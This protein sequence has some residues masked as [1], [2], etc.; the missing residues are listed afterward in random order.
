MG[1]NLDPPR[2]GDKAFDVGA[3]NK[4]TGYFNERWKLWFGGLYNYI[5]SFISPTGLLPPS[6]TTAQRDALTNVI[7]R[8]IIWVS[9]IPALQIS[10]GGTW[11][12]FT[13]S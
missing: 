5:L 12:T 8:T 9:D 10:I 3:D 4:V 1:L 11:Y 6:L 2:I 7:D 13:V